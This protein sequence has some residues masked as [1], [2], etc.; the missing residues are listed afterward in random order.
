MSA[1][2]SAREQ[3]GAAGVRGTF[4]RSL[5]N[6]QGYFPRLRRGAAI[7]GFCCKSSDARLARRE[8]NL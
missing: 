2:D 7:A 3:L 6:L 4:D 5:G 8:G 1:R